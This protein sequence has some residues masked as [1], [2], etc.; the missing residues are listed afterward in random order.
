MTAR[1]VRI[2]EISAFELLTIVS[3]F[4]VAL[5]GAIIAYQAYR[6]YRRNDATSML[7]LAL[8]LLLLTVCPFV[9]NVAINTV[10]NADHLV[11]VFFENVSR[12]LGLLA[13]T[14]SLYGR[15]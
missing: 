7:Y 4:L 3:L 1:T 14:Y 10:T 9:V 6:G 15:H 8:G 12:L 13:I 2:D 5:M 11:T